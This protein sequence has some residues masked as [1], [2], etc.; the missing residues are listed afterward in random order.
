MVSGLCHSQMGKNH[1]KNIDSMSSSEWITYR[2]ELLDRFYQA[3]HLLIP[4][5]DCRECDPEN[6]YVCFNCECMQI[7]KAMGYCDL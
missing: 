3:G 1:M 4:S 5:A 2:D 6:E 7:D